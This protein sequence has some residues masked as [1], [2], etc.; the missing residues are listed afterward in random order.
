MKPQYAAAS[1]LTILALSGCLGKND[2]TDYTE[3]RKT[4]EAYVTTVQDS[5]SPQGTPLYTKVT[6]DWAPT[7][8]IMMKWHND[9]ALTASA[10][11]PRD[12]S[13]VDV[14]YSLRNING[15]LIDSSWARRDSIYRCRPCNNVVGFWRALTEMHVGDHVTAVVPWTAGYGAFGSGSISPYTTL[16]FDIRL[17]AIEGFETPY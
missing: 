13:T 5:V 4:N 1:L 12:N 9:R 6:P 15:T 14:I 10:L 17:K 7:A 2:S 16:V 11:S 8:W 3:W